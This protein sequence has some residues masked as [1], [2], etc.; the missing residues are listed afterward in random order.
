MDSSVAVPL[1]EKFAVPRLAVTVFASV[2]FLEL[3]V[4]KVWLTEAPSP[5]T[6]PV[7]MKLPALSVAE[8]LPS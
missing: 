4:P 7:R 5:E 1:E 3:K 6:K 2:T 8:V